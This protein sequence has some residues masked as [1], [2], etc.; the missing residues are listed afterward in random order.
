[1]SVYCDVL[2]DLYLFTTYTLV[3]TYKYIY[4]YAY[5]WYVDVA[6]AGALSKK[7]SFSLPTQYQFG[8]KKTQ[9]RLVNIV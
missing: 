2:A 7:I 3:Y 5:I 4:V 8:G 6:A 1:M 9:N